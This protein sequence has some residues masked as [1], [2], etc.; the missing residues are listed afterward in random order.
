MSTG[1][2]TR[3]DL[4]E[5]VY[6]EIGLSRTESAELVEA[7]ID[8]IIDALLR[9]ETVKLAGFGTFTMRDKKERM[10]RNPKTGEAVPITPRR[11]LSFKPSQVVR[12]RVNTALSPSARKSE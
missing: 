7:V 10:G 8:N 5:A 9:G 1:T 4:T 2:V 3:A 11:V 6:R 12:E